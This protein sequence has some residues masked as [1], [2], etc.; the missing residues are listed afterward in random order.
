MDKE[1][2]PGFGIFH[3]DLP[4][5]AKDHLVEWM[6]MLKLRRKDARDVL[7]ETGIVGIETGIKPPEDYDEIERWELIRRRVLELRS[8]EN[9]DY[10]DVEAMTAHLGADAQNE[11]PPKTLAEMLDELRKNRAVTAEM[12]KKA[13]QQSKASA[14]EKTKRVRKDHASWD[15]VIDKLVEEGLLSKKISRQA[16]KEM[17][18]RHHPDYPWDKV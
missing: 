2:K 1:I 5:W 3:P 10:G 4:P 6:R 8:A 12:L 11:I 7:R 16:F 18:K 13:K 15:Y 9:E 17:L 14:Q